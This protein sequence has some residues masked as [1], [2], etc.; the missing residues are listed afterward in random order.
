VSDSASQTPYDFQSLGL[1]KPLL[2]CPHRGMF[3]R[4]HQYGIESA[5][6]PHP[7]GVPPQQWTVCAVYTLDL[8]ALPL[9]MQ[10]FSNQALGLRAILRLNEIQNMQRWICSR[11][12]PQQSGESCIERKEIA[13]V[14]AVAAS[15]WSVLE[16]ELNFRF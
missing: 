16:K 3:F 6:L 12:T 7:P 14:I 4:R 10:Q 5:G 8:N 9:L 11:I 15:E 1:A 13:L 2:G